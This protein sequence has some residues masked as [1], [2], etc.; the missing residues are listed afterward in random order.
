MAQDLALFHV[1]RPSYIRWYALLDL[2][3]RCT[4][5]G[6]YTFPTRVLFKMKI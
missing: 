6:P 3:F 5:R 1:V 2:G 4:H